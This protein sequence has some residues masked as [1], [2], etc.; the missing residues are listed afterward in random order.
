MMDAQEDT[1]REKLRQAMFAGWDAK[2]GDANPYEEGT[3]EA[4]MFDIGATMRLTG[5]GQ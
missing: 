1:A 3:W 5:G 4:T 2:E